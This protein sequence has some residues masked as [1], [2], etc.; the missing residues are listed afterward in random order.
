MKGYVLDA[1]WS[2][3]RDVPICQGI[4]KINAH[5]VPTIIISVFSL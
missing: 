2:I 3:M 4:Y 5:R 1:G